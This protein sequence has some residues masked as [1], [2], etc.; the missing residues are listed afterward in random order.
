MLS[1][2]MNTTDSFPGKKDYVSIQKGVHKQKQLVLSNLHELL[3]ASKKINPEVK[4]GSPSFVVSAL[5]GVS[6]HVH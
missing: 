2:N 1:V 6:L 4:T 5:N 3:V